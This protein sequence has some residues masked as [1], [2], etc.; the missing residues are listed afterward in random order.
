MLLGQLLEKILPI[1]IE[2]KATSGSTTTIGDTNLIGKYDTDAF[3]DGIAFIHSTTDGLAPTGQYGTVTGFVDA[4][5]VFTID[6]TLTAVVASGDYYSI[7]DPQFTIIP[8]LRVVNDALRDFGLIA[9]VD[10]SITS[11]ADTLE[12][13][14][15]LAL[16]AFPLDRVELGNV[17]DGWHE[18][19]DWYVLPATGGAQGKIVFNSQPAYD[20]S[21]AANETFRL[22]YRSY[23]PTVDT[24]EDT[25][26]E[27]IPEARAVKECRVALQKYMMERDSDFS[28]EALQKLGMFNNDLQESKRTQ[29]VNVP[30]RK[31]SKFLSVRDM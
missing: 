31:L 6:T 4:T 15:P 14:L 2:G 23:H 3:K 19:N 21:T 11:A 26:S 27:T 18:L 13:S 5:G 22:W 7:A 9:L 25:I 20:G 8:L 28:K 24:Y 16:K 30:N 1:Q 29:L 17:T 12:Y 10:T